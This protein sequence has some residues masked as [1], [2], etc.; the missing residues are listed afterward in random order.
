M[1]CVVGCGLLLFDV[2]M[3]FVVCWLV[4]NIVACL[5]FVVRRSA[6]VVRCLLLVACCLVVDCCLLF[7]VVQCCSLFCVVCCELCDVS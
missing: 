7:G 2:C 3:L 1:L 4:F 5:V 6:F